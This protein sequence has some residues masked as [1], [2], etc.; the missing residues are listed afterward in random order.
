MKIITH[1]QIMNAN[2]TNHE[3]YE[4]VDYVLKHRAE[5]ELPLKTRLP[6]G[7][8]NYFNVMPC[9]MPTE[10]IMGVKVVTRNQE[11]RKNGGLN[12]EAQ[13]LLYRYDTEEILALIDGNWIT[14]MRTAAIAVHS[15]IHCSV[16][17]RKIAFL[18]V[19][20]IGTAVADIL[21]TI[22]PD[23]PFIINV[24]KYKDQAER[25]VR[26]YESL[27]NVSLNIYDDPED[28]VR[29]CD[30]VVSCVT[31]ADADFCSASTYKPGCTVIPV[32]MRGF[33][34]C[35][36]EFDHVISSDL[37]GIKKFKYYD[38]IKKLSLLDD[39]IYKPNVIRDNPDD[40][41][42]VYN[43]GI[44]LYD[45]YYAYKVYEKISNV[46]ICEDLNP[47]STYYI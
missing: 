5:Y 46:C 2:I 30:V 34:E 8:S 35:D 10:N 40:K 37:E 19:G 33:M 36:K 27:K 9:V 16:N 29:D 41:V 23:E 14:T 26:R 20:N 32:H 28:V 45:I 31:Y 21:F 24:L 25:F 22:R 13:I 6:L 15:L 11:R 18:G 43:L 17:R 3:C 47:E 4:W 44:A 7:K 39:V 12:I 38:R 1:K 42:I